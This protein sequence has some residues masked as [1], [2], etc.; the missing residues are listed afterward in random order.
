MVVLHAH[1]FVEIA[2]IPG[3]AIHNLH[4]VRVDDPDRLPFGKPE[5]RAVGGRNLDRSIVVHRTRFIA[6]RVNAVLALA[7][8]KKV[9]ALCRLEENARFRGPKPRWGRRRHLQTDRL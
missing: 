1:M 5:C 8:C 6:G 4:A 3:P 7:L 9:Q 2:R